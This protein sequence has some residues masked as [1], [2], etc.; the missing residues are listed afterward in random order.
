MK[1]THDSRLPLYYQI[2]DII[3]DK[4]AKEIW[5]KGTKIPSERELCD[6]YDVS[7][8]TVRKAIEEL[9]HNGK[10]EKLHG[11]GTFVSS[12]PINQNLGYIYSFSREMEKQGKISSTKMVK[13]EIELADYKI[14][15]KLQIKE[16]DP[17]IVLYRLRCANDVPLMY[18][19]TYFRKDKYSDLL[20]IDLSKVGLYET[21]ENHFG[22][23]STTA[24]ERFTACEL[25]ARE[26]ELLNSTPKSFGLL[27]QRTLYVGEEVVSWS[28]LVSKGDSF[29]FTV[30]LES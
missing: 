20:K 24:V 26:A 12:Q 8:I 4:I 30:V 13:I 17:I 7:R 22:I 5:P 25:T 15:S 6:L 14:A 19:R 10:L 16:H 27:V 9:V 29:E 3:E 28:S 21:L 11:K 1:V 2:I 23:K 18:E